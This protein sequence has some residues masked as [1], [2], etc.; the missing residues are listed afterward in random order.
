MR[1]AMILALGVLGSGSWG[2][3]ATAAEMIPE[4]QVVRL[5]VP[6]DPTI[7]FRLWFAVGS[8]NDP[9]GKEGLAEL[10]AAMLADA[11]TQRNRYEQILDKL[12]PLAATYYTS[13]SEE[14]TIVGGRIHKDNLEAYYPLLI[15]AVLRPAFRQ[16][17]LER[18]RSQALNV[19]EN[20]LRY[21]GDEDLGKAV[22][23]SR[24][25]AGTRYAHIPTGLIESVRG[26]TL[27]DVRKFYQEHFRRGNL[28]IG[29][30]GGYEEGLVKRLRTDLFPL[31]AGRPAEVA[32][33]EPPPI[34]GLHVTIVEKDCAATAISMGFPISILRGPRPWYALALANSYLGEHRNS[35]SH[36]YQVIR[37]ARGLNYG[38]YSYIEHFPNGSHLQMPLQNVARRKQMF[39]IWIRPVPHE[40]RHFALRAALREFKKLVDHGMEQSD[41]DLTRKFLRNYVLH[42]APTTTE[43]LGYALDDRFYGIRGSHLENYRRT[44]GELTLDEVNAAIEKHWQ[45]GDMQIVIVTKDAESLKKALVENTPSPCNY[46]TPKPESVLAEDR[47]ISTFP[48][49]IQPENVEIVP[50]TGLFVK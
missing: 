32:P 15:D 13:V 14:M 30:G 7:S 16:D 50:V 18:L 1:F 33:P 20:V 11:A 48:L 19:L 47:E 4:S 29:I 8:Q 39:E 25:F 46:P 12:F 27:D 49:V 5:P 3:E 36:L 37:E 21:A 23:Q 44:M 35:S 9:P 10:T 34:R 2:D 24:V 22:L 40:A 41:F 43:R 26:I 6:Q 28:V 31:P 45:Y 17:D 38:D 42:F